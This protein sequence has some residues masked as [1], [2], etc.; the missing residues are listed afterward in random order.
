MIRIMAKNKKQLYL[1]RSETRSPY[2]TIEFIRVIKGHT[3]GYEGSFE[4]LQNVVFLGL[5]MLR[6][7]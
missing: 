2:V 4:L 1:R 5:V 6:V 7:H 3:T